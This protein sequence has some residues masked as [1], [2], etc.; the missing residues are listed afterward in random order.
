MGIID[1]IKDTVMGW[2]NTALYT[3]KS[4]AYGLY[5]SVW[6][7]ASQISTD[8]WKETGLIWDRI[9][10]IPL[11]TKDVIEGWVKPLINTAKNSVIGLLNVAVDRLEG[12]IEG[13]KAYAETL[14]NNAIAVYDTI[15]IELQGQV[16]KMEQWI[17]DSPEW[18][19]TLL[20]TEHVRIVT[21]I[22][23]YAEEILDMLFIPEGDK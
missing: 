22:A 7:Y 18:L 1:E 11:L 21:F 9:G 15:I 3:A 12:L 20:Y 16:N 14:V 6:D 5:T 19:I 2:I 8:L 4:Y 23:D 13:A 10:A 17:K